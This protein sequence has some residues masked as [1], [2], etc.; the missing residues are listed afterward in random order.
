MNHSALFRFFVIALPALLASCA[1]PAYQARGYASYIADQYAGHYTTSGAIY[2]PQ[3]WTAAHNTLPF[4]TV[5]KVKNNYNGRTVNV[6][7]NDRFPYYPNRVINLSRRAAEYIQIPYHQLSDVTVTADTI[8]GGAAPSSGY[9]APAPATY[10][11][12]P[13]N[14]RAPAPAPK[15]TVAV[16]KKSAPQNYYSPPASNYRR[17]TAIPPAGAGTMAPPAG[18]PPPPPGYEG[19]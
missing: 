18:L 10:P 9:A 13:S 15:K 17:P 16:K 3:D 4:G 12:P 19:R 14:Y 11:T 6:T 2:Q 1:K 7:V 5:V 8:P